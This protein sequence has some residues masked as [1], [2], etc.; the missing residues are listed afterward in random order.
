M[1]LRDL[2]QA[3][4]QQVQFL[5]IYIEEAHPVDGWWFGNNFMGRLLKMKRSKAAMD[6]FDPRSMEERQLIAQRCALMLDYEIPTLVDGIDNAV[7]WAYAALP[8]RLYLIG[9]D[10][11]VEYAST[12][13]PWGFKPSQLE[14]AIRQTLKNDGTPPQ[15]RK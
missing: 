14:K 4:H 2:Y 8:T 5:V 6:I 3:Y 7:N 9:L 13:G 11:R 10:G 1:R 15:E 12:P